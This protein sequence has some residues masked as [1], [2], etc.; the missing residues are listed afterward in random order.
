MAK[1]PGYVNKRCF[2]DGRTALEVAKKNNCRVR[3]GNGD[4]FIVYNQDES[5]SIV[6]V[7]REMGE[8]LGRK[9][10]KTFVKWGV[11][12]LSFYIIYFVIVNQVLAFGG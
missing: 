12:A 3:N 2:D 10:F 8:G 4:H 5:E 7:G 9:I 6:I 1:N 11:I